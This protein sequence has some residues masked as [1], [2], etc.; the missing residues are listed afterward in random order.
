MGSQRT[1]LGRTANGRPVGRWTLRNA[2]HELS[3]AELGARW[4]GW[5]VGGSQLLIGPDSVPAIERD[6]CFIGAVVGRYANRLAGGRFSLDG[7]EFQIPPNEGPNVLHGG[8]GGLWAQIWDAEPGTIDGDPCVRLGIVSPDGDQ[9]FPGTLKVDATYILG[10][11][12]VRLDYR[13]I[14]DAPTVLNLANHAYFNL[15]GQPDVLGHLVQVAA[16]EVVAVDDAALPTGEFW[17]VVGSDLDLRNPRQLGALVESADPRIS[18]ARGIDHCYVLDPEAEV[19][20]RLSCGHLGVEVLTDQPGLQV[21]FG[22]HLAGDWQPYQ[23]M[24]LETQ[25]F[26]DAP[27]QP[28]FP[29]TTLAPGIEWTSSTT[30]RLA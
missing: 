29:D 27:N 21:Y 8:A 28:Q 11:G 20:A 23:G 1:D 24:C 22:Q 5:Q 12:W 30:W 6:E 14:S 26:P 7:R 3:I 18:S 13:A 17:P 10:D 9:G 4:L 15:G 16:A 19:A 2:G 25:H